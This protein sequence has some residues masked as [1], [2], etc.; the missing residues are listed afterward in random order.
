[1]TVQTLICDLRGQRPGDE[2]SPHYH[3]HWLLLNQTKGSD[4]LALWGSTLVDF[5]RSAEGFI[6]C[7]QQNSFIRLLRDKLLMQ[8]FLEKILHKKVAN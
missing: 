2:S 3:E 8:R 5:N 6:V 1:M 7:S 4:T